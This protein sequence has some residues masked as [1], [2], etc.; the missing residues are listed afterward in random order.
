MMRLSLLTISLMISY[1]TTAA[2]KKYIN[3]RSIS[4]N[5]STRLRVDSSSCN[6]FL[7]L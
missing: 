7:G 2:K 3:E 4:S 5:R 1:P 6:R